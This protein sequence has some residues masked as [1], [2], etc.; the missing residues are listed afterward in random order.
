MGILIVVL[1]VAVLALGWWVMSGSSSGSH[2][3]DEQ[4]RWAAPEHE[5][6]KTRAK[7]PIPAWAL[8]LMIAAVLFGIG[9]IVLQALGL[10]DNPVLG[11]AVATLRPL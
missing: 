2:M 7:R 11:D 10:G 9:I 5:Q 6:D 3:T 4:R 1:V 8:G